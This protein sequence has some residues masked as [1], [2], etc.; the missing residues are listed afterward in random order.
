MQSWLPVVL[1][2]FPW[3]QNVSYGPSPAVVQG[4]LTWLC[5]ACFLLYAVAAHISSRQKEH[6]IFGAWALA[7]LVSACMGLLQYFGFTAWL[8]G[9]VTPAELGQAFG[10]LRQRN[11]FST[12]MSIGFIAVL[13]HS[14]KLCRA[15][16]WYQYGLYL[17]IAVL[18]AAS[19]ASGSRTGLLQWILILG[20]Y[21][22][23]LPDK[24]R[25][26]VFAMLAYGLAA[27]V[28]PL[29]LGSGMQTSGIMSRLHEN[30]PVCTSR[31]TLW[32]NV[33]HLISQKPLWGWGWGMLD[34]AYFVTLFPTERFCGIVDNAHNLPLQ[35]AVELGLP[36]ATLFCAAIV[37]F[38]LFGKPWR[39]NNRSKQAA[40][41]V[42]VAI[43]LHSLLEY[44]LWYAPFQLATLLAVYLLISDTH[45]L[46]TQVAKRASFK[47]AAL[48]SML[49]LFTTSLVAFD[50]GRMSQ[51]YL[52]V[53]SRVKVFETGVL[54]Q[55]QSSWFFKDMVLFAKLSTTPLTLQNAADVY[56]NA[57]HLLTLS[58]EPRVIEKL[59][60]SAIMLGKTEVIDAY[61]ARYHAAFPAEAKRWQSLNALK[62]NALPSKSR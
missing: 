20:I 50:Y 25:F 15:R 18:A 41:A 39:E 1:L 32:S 28:L 61:L 8:Q 3:L 42:L 56:A 57:T 24:R 27:V 19:A 30:S 22:V 33:L 29:A 47:A 44:P 38:V 45:N 7:A 48:I 2:T 11:Q 10:N 62:I 36:M 26:L 13:W 40:W 46:N 4:L 54:G 9:V 6:F 58:P 51:I 31:L 17:C 12:L 37:G 23:W 59:L 14:Q 49:V 53:A 55:P 21:C 34:Y 5:F 52:P 16:T 60:E 35:W 43:G